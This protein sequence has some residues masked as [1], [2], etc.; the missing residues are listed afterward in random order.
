MN[1][2][3]AYFIK[4][5]PLISEECKVVILWYLGREIIRVEMAKIAEN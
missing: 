1:F 2:T 3:G 4:Y 5:I